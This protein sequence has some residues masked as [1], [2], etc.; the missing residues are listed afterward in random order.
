MKQ[1]D[2]LKTLIDTVFFDGESNMQ[3]TGQILKA[4][5]PKISVLLEMEHV[6]SLMFE[7]ISKIKIVKVRDL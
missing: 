1:V 5:F 4:I 7:D 6:L 2:P 3:L